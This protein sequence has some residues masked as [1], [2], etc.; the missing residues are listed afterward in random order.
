MVRVMLMF[1]EPGARIGPL[2]LPYQSKTRFNPDPLLAAST[3][4]QKRQVSNE[5]CILL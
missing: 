3:H 5:H 2:W 4:A 1:I